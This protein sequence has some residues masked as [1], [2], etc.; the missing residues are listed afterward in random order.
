[1]LNSTETNKMAKDKSESV[2]IETVF[3]NPMT[4]GVTYAMFLE[5]KGETPIKEYCKELDSD[6]IEWIESEIENYNNNNKKN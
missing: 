1:M 3:V 2:T 5:A 4:E 6:T